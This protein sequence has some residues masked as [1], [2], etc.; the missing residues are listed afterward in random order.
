VG[1]STQD[2]RLVEACRDTGAW[3]ALSYCR[4]T[5]PVLATKL[6]NIEKHKQSIPLDALPLTIR[7]AVIVTRELGLRYLWVDS[8]CIIQDSN[9]DWLQEA[10]TMHEVYRNA[11]VTIGAEASSGSH[12]GIFNGTNP[13]R[14]TIKTVPGTMKAT[15]AG[16]QGSISFSEPVPQTF[17]FDP[18]PLSERAWALQEDLLSRRHI[19]FALHQ[20][21]WRCKT[22]EATEVN[23][24]GSS[25]SVRWDVHAVKEPFDRD[26][27]FDIVNRFGARQITFAKDRLSA[28]AAL[29]RV[30]GG[31][32]LCRDYVAGLWLSHLPEALLWVTDTPRCTKTSSAPSWSRASVHRPDPSAGRSQWFYNP[33]ARRLKPAPKWESCRCRL[34]SFRPILT[35]PSS[36]EGFS[37]FQDCI[38]RSASAGYQVSA[39][40][41]L[42]DLSQMSVVAGPVNTRADALA[43]LGTGCCGAH[44]GPHLRRPPSTAAHRFAGFSLGAF[45]PHPYD[46]L[47]TTIN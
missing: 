35:D 46:P 45:A 19:R 14:Q 12:V 21:Y 39:L 16:I 10:A 47:S 26:Q 13:V 8:L 42:R 33:M 23:I 25:P 20:I 41:S 24:R 38:L 32:K 28:I 2:P 4:G 1:S 18:G 11:A 36:L 30:Y 9:T 17:E 5:A 31:S 40:T 29:A 15:A 37:A 6:G 43:S 3:A 22:M 7:D 44:T 34:G 27:W